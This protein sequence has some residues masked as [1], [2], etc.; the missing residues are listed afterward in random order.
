MFF[1]VKFFVIKYMSDLVLKCKGC[2]FKIG[3]GSLVFG[4]VVD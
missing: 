1:I 2:K 4:V 3:L